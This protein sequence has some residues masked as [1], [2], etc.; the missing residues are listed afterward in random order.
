MGGAN[1][2]L[3]KTTTRRR[4]PAAKAVSAGASPELTSKLGEALAIIDE[5]KAEI[6]AL[7]DVRSNSPMEQVHVDI[8][9]YML[10]CPPDCSEWHYLSVQELP[11]QWA[12]G[13]QR[14]KLIAKG[15]RI[16]HEITKDF[17]IMRI[18]RKLWLQR[19]EDAR[20]ADLAQRS[21]KKS[22]VAT[23]ETYSQTEREFSEFV[24]QQEG[25]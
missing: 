7:K 8:P 19:E 18:P 14:N 9:D 16:F 4:K 3:K 10:E 17:C 1:L 6:A 23:K 13:S 25:V 21:A 12:L 22:D 11:D 20:K 24:Q 15:Y 5:M 2:M